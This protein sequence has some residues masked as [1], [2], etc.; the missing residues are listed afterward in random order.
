M[1][2]EV[3]GPYAESLY[4]KEKSIFNY[5]FQN[6]LCKPNLCTKRIYPVS[7]Q[8]ER[9]SGALNEVVIDNNRASDQQE[10][11]DYYCPKDFDKQEML[12]DIFLWS[13]YEGYIDTAFVL[14]LQLKTRISA[15]LI[16]AGM[17]HHLSLISPNLHGRNLYDKH[18]EALEKYASQCIDVCY[19]QNERKAS[20][21]LLREIPLFGNITCMQVHY[22]QL[23]IET[24]ICLYI[25]I[26]GHCNA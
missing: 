5:I 26:G 3:I 10:K 15:A 16:A 18:R 23:K 11:S 1:Y 2:F 19:S 25:L 12:R 6:Y 8:T 9:A 7:D 4:Y 22:F 24:N 17:A 14:L 20:E 13:V 21:L